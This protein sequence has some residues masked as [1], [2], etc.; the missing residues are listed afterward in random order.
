MLLL[1]QPL[2]FLVS[3]DNKPAKTYQIQSNAVSNVK[4]K[5]G[6]CSGVK[7]N[8]IYGIKGFS[9]AAT[10]SEQKLLGHLA[11][12][13]MLRKDGISISYERKYHL[14]TAEKAAA[15]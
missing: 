7:T 4:I 15:E 10:Q 9:I 14:K 2:L 1:K 13:R 3:D 12:N 8:T 5:P 11:G 6:Q